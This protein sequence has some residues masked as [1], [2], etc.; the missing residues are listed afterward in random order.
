MISKIC[1]CVY[2]RDNEIDFYF[3]LN[4]NLSKSH[5]RQNC[6]GV[7]WEYMVVSRNKENNDM[8]RLVYG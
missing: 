1:L 3:Q 5:I 2:F 4:A 7:V 8:F 6:V